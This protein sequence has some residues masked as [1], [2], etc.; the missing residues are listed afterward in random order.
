MFSLISNKNRNS[1]VRHSARSPDINAHL[2]LDLTDRERDFLTTR[3]WK[4]LQAKKLADKGDMAFIPERS[5]QVR[6]SEYDFCSTNVEDPR[7]GSHFRATCN[8]CIAR[9]GGLVPIRQAG[10]R[11]HTSIIR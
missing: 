11:F 10:G 7:W 8:K 4:A 5:K 2:L 1:A 9:G 3:R 6:S